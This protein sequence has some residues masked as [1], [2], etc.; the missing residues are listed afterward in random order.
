MAA[1][2]SLPFITVE[3]Y[4]ASHYEP[5][6]DF[7]DGVLE[8]RSVGE[9]DHGDL[10]GQ[11][12]TMFR[13][14]A[15]AWKIR[16][17]TETRVQVSATRFRVPDV[18]VVAASSPREQIVRTAPLLCIEVL[19]PE[20][21]F[22]RSV[23]KFGDYIAMGVP[24]VWIFD[25]TSRAAHVLDASGKTVAYREGSLRLAGTPIEL[26]LSEVFATLDDVRAE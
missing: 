3:E 20:D 26:K 11:I 16:A 4:L 24:E 17:V 25:P 12:V 8:E 7:V 19:S 9:Y 2:V 15:G 18:C 22:V 14:H 21:R 5:D 10:Q 6:A 13:N 23:K 1:A